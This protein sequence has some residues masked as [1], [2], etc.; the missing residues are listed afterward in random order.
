MST[1]NFVPQVHQVHD[2]ARVSKISAP[3][4]PQHFYVRTAEPRW[5]Y[6]LSFALD[7]STDLTGIGELR[8]VVDL[9]VETGAVGVGWHERGLFRV[10]RSRDFCI[11]RGAAQSLCANR[12]AGRCIASGAAKRKSGR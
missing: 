8:V 12:S 4:R 1:L 7:T 5:R 2:G 11:S 3:E 10:C 9:E 6:A